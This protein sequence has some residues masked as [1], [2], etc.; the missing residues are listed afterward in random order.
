MN[1]ISRT[2]ITML[3]GMILLSAQVNAKDFKGV[4]SYKITYSGDDINDQMKAFLPKVMTI[5]FKGML[6]RTDII[7]G[8]GKTVKIKNGEDKSV[9]TLIDMMGQK[10]AVKTSAE[11]VQK[12][13][14]SEMSASVEVMNETKEILGHTC[15]KAVITMTGETGNEDIIVVYF[16]ESLGNN[17]NYFDTPEFKDIDGIMLEFEIPT[18]EFT[19]KFTASSI[20]KKNVSKTDFEIPE[21]FEIK[22]KEEVEAMF[23]GM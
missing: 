7:M 16:T 23:G 9:I 20:E 15:K 11:E 14:E 18:P 21:D 2:A 17:S 10:I 13:L 12:D 8:M 4:I 22:T 1:Q 6:T 3:I 19:M 5:R